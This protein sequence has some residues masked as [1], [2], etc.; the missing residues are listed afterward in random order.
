[1]PQL[2]LLALATVSVTSIV[3]LVS[4]RRF[5]SRYHA[6]NGEL[7]PWNWMFRA[8]ADPEL[9][10]LRR[11]ALSTLP[12]FLVSLVLYLGQTY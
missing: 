9:E 5:A 10:R 6:K 3:M 2:A 1:V 12:V 11:V 8:T 4:G 7:P